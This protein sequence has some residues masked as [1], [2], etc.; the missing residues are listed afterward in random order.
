[1][2]DKDIYEEVADRVV[3]KCSPLIN[4]LSFSFDGKKMI[5]DAVLAALAEVSCMP[6]LPE[7]SIARALAERDGRAWLFTVDPLDPNS[8]ILRDN[9]VGDARA[10]IESA[11][12]GKK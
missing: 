3:H 4:S 12:N 8:K 11:R 9:Y 7:I 5:R 2:K 10:L 6:P 1:M